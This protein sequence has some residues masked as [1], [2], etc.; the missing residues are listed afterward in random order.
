MTLKTL[1]VYTVILISVSLVYSSVNPLRACGPYDDTPASYSFFNPGQSLKQDDKPQNDN[2]LEWESFFKNKT[3]LKDIGQVV[4][5]LKVK[6]L[7][8]VK[9]NMEKEAKLQFKFQGNSLLRYLFSKKKLEV[10]DYLLFAKEC[11]PYVG[12]YGGWDEPK[13]DKKAMKTLIKRGLKAYRKMKSPFI[14]LRYAYQITRLA[15]YAQDNQQTIKLYDQYAKPL[16]V[17]SIMRY[18]ALNHKAGALRRMKLYAKAA[19]LFSRVYDLCPSRRISAYRSFLIQ[20]D[21]QWKQAL[22]LCKN[23][24]E[25]ATLHTLRALNPENNALE[26][27]KAVYRLDPTSR[28]LKDIATKQING[29]EGELLGYQLKDFY[30]LGKKAPIHVRKQLNDLIQFVNKVHGKQTGYGKTF[31]SITLAYLNYMGSNFDEA[32]KLI[33]V[34]KGQYMST[35]LMDRVDRIDLLIQLT[36]LTKVGKQAENILY[37]KVM[38]HQ[39][40]SVF[41]R[42]S[43]EWFFLNV[44]EKLYEKQGEPGKAFFCNNT[45]YGLLVSPKIE[46]VNDLLKIADKPNK[47][48]FEKDILGL[49]RE[50]Q[51]KQVLLEIK[52]T[53]KLADHKLKEAIRIFKQLPKS[54]RKDYKPFQIASDPFQVIFND[55]RYKPSGKTYTKLSLAERLFELEQKAKVSTRTGLGDYY[56]LGTAY[57]NMT[58]YGNA[59]NAVDYYK[60]NY[61]SA[62][63]HDDYVDYSRPLKYFN[64]VMK[65][66]KDG[67]LAA[68]AC[69]MAAKCEQA[70]FYS[71]KYYRDYDSNNSKN[72]NKLFRKYFKEL[73]TTYSD[74]KYYREVIKEC[75]FFDHY[76]NKN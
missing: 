37:R 20:T 33:K 52:G 19:Y 34:L 30:P 18:W 41:Y 9:T 55:F 27:M 29:L 50:D 63:D 59:W 6:D 61:R 21:A 12:T 2:L 3:T 69:F 54:F 51:K 75:G 8:I 14:K 56:L 28:H 11:E 15:H 74:T 58:Y 67:E 42:N 13:I 49:I 36:Q 48:A 44:F 68:K 73:K 53:L 26:E 62:D 76:V 40:V 71:S 5:K 32:S 35:K 65:S 31:W 60:S 16:K 57:Y 24:G 23:N 64:T 72:Q 43:M 47:T 10:I 1:R 22:A 45:F 7:Q 70:Q 46:V 17:K 4:Y 39:I 66:T 38:S 25:K